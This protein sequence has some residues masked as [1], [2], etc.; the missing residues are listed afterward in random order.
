LTAFEIASEVRLKT[1]D[2]LWLQI[3]MEA[4]AKFA[5]DADAPAPAEYHRM[6][7]WLG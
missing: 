1:T 3:R 6:F 7:C 5:S 2:G 4:L